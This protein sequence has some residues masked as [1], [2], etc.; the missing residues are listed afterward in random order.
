[1]KLRTRPTRK[2]YPRGRYYAWLILSVLVTVPA[3]CVEHP[4]LV[5]RDQECS[6]CHADKIKGKS[7]HSAMAT[8]CTVCHV[9]QIRGDMLTVSLMMPK[10][11]ICSACHQQSAMLRQHVPAVKGSCVDCHDSHSSERASLLREAAVVNPPKK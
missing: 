11:K 7:V 3:W 2:D 8:P 4:G 10:E 5:A 9:A 6:S 1:M